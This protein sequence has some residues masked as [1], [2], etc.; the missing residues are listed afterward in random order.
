MFGDPLLMT[1][2]VSGILALAITGRFAALML[3]PDGHW[4]VR[5]L[6]RETGWVADENPGGPGISA[7]HG[8]HESGGCTLGQD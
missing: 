3:L 6:D 7:N 5:L 2:C 8:G 4:L 1:L